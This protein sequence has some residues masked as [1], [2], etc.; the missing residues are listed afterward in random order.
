LT[1]AVDSNVLLDLL[2]ADSPRGHD[3]QLALEHW[4]SLGALVMSEPV[5]AECSPAF[6]SF[7]ELDQFL[8]AARL[9]LVA[10]SAEALFEAGQVWKQYVERRPRSL[11][12]ARCGAPNN[13]SC[14]S[15]GQAI[16]SRQHLVR[17]FLIGAH[18]SVH[19]DRLLTRDRG[20]YREYFSRLAVVEY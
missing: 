16:Q 6:T 12:C 19:A 14:S 5:Y 13:V 15:C 11:L 18:A 10:S 20:F 1:T 3:A 2:S 4:S 7:E 17:D 8:G 9:Q